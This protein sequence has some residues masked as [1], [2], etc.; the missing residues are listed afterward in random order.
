MA[1]YSGEIFWQCSTRY[2]SVKER[3]ALVRDDGPIG[4]NTV[5]ETK[6]ASYGRTLKFEW[7]EV[8]D[9]SSPVAWRVR[10][11]L[12]GTGAYVVPYP[13]PSTEYNLYWYERWFALVVRGDLYAGAPGPYDPLPFYDPNDG[14]SNAN[15]LFSVPSGCSW[16]GAGARMMRNDGT[17]IFIQGIGWL[18]GGSPDLQHPCPV[19][20][21]Y[22]SPELG[23]T[24]WELEYAE[25]VVPRYYG[26]ENRPNG[27]FHIY[28]ESRNIY[29][30]LQW[31]GRNK[32]TNVWQG[33]FYDVG[34]TGYIRV[35]L[36]FLRPVS[37]PTTGSQSLHSIDKAHVAVARANQ[38]AR[39]NVFSHTR[40]DSRQYFPS[41]HVIRRV[42]QLPRFGVVLALGKYDTS[43][44]VRMCEVGSD[45]QTEVMS[46]TATSAM[47]EIAE[48][49]RTALLVYL[50]SDGIVYRRLSR[51]GGWTWD[52]AQP[53]TVSGGGDMTAMLLADLDYSPRRRCWLLAVQTGT[54]TFK[55]YASEDGLQW[56]ATA[57]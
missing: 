32:Y 1:S 40:V 23:D 22:D 30:V 38:I 21:D 55:V 45:R 47:I 31:Y 56:Q 53:C 52:E 44:S 36:T 9:G 24:M 25:N 54:N 26:I 8:Y 6:E 51:D 14:T 39:C 57:L 34:P 15:N 46:L 43:Y 13:D 12:Y 5:I 17:R 27:R 48:D 33:P 28:V 4:S 10:F 29:P 37:Q 3:A 11:V 49:Q 35:E 42:R 19:A 50:S 18:Y 16:T 41:T 2:G 7:P 20:T